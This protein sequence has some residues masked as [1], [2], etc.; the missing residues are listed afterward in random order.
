M[1]ENQSLWS[2]GKNHKLYIRVFLWF[3]VASD[4]SQNKDTFPEIINTI[5]LSV[6]G[7]HSWTV[8]DF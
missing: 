4:W 8:N 5:F 1:F 7:F 6:Y 3:D 2:E